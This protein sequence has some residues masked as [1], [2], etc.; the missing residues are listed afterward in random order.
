MSFQGFQIRLQYQSPQRGVD[1]FPA[2]TTV[3]TAS[4]E[5]PNLSQLGA[6]PPISL[7]LS[8]ANVIFRTPGQAVTFPA[9]DFTGLVITRVSRDMPDFASIALTS[10]NSAGIPENRLSFDASSIAVNL[11]GLNLGPNQ[12]STWVVGFRYV[13]TEVGDDLFG[14]RGGDRLEGLAG[15]D[16][17]EGAQAND[18]I[19]GGAGIDVARVSGLRADY[20]VSAQ[21]AQW[22]L[23]DSIADRDGVDTLSG[24]ERVRFGDG[25]LALDIALPGQGDSNAGT[26][27]RLYKATFNRTPDQEGLAF[28][29]KEL[30]KGLTTRQAAEFFAS[31]AEFRTIYGANP[32][33]DQLV[34]S[35]YTNILGRAPEQ[36]G[37]DFWFNILNGQPG[38]RALVLENIANSIENQNGLIATIGQGVFLPGD[39]LA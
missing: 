6:A 25:T 34:R 5:F 26:A 4:T 24:V 18:T 21:G 29:I 16:T 11:Q 38:N 33:A 13:G 8:S 28:W 9:G 20:A 7:D 23:T 2:R 30:D 19:D 12:G 15:N 17:L 10:S 14:G 27:Y 39:L 31:S 22:R 3:A 37:F 1:V 36:A 35:F 32:S